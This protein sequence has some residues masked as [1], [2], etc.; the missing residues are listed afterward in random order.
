MFLVLSQFR[1]SSSSPLQQKAF[2]SSAP[3]Q[4]LW[5]WNQRIIG[6]FI[7]R[8][9]N[10][11]ALGLHRGASYTCGAVHRILHPDVRALLP[12]PSLRV[13]RHLPSR[14]TT[15]S[16]SFPLQ[17]TEG[18]DFLHSSSLCTMAMA[19]A[20]HL[21]SHHPRTWSGYVQRRRRVT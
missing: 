21:T 15:S 17:P 20:P 13:S 14:L 8:P 2:Y 12:P 1:Y 9:Q 16:P 4:R 5:A 6:D 19:S 7:L 18:I 11:L 10:T 3:L